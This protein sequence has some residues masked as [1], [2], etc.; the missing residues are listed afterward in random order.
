[1]IRWHR[2]GAMLAAA[3]LCAASAAAGDQ[4][5]DGRSERWRMPRDV[6]MLTSRPD[7]Y[8]WRLFVAL[9]WPVDLST[10]EPDHHA[11]LGADRPVV[12]ES[13]PSARELLKPDGSDPGRWRA[14][15]A[16]ATP[17]QR[18]ETMSLKELPNLRHIVGGVMVPVEDPIASARRLTDI[19]FNRT[20]FEFIRARQLFNVNGQV[21]AYESGGSI[22]LPYGAV[23]VKAKWRQ[24]EERERTR[25]HTLEVTMADGTRRLYG[26]TALHIAS[27][28]RPDWFW[29]TF[30]H[31]DNPTLPDSEG[32]L[33]PSRDRFACRG[34]QA[35]CNR[36]P[37]GLGLEGTV[38]SNYRLR[39]TMT[40]YV[41]AQGEPERLANSELETDMQRTASCVTCH[42]RAS[43]GVREH[44][45]VHRSILD[46]AVGP[47]A[48]ATQRRGFVGEPLWL[49]SPVPDNDVRMEPVDFVW[50]LA[51]VRVTAP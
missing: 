24:I 33:L 36:A 9:N 14:S 20:S 44:Q 25:Y 43:I 47:D 21:R 16:P 35:D 48:D 39:G 50:S 10:R 51:G 23:N 2:A 38:W 7:E 4:G 11:R 15:R 22:R 12:W 28:D 8:A 32:W 37:S 30:E 46:V 19:H 45:L 41:N 13:W 29:S 31:V 18:F 26:L 49:K 34:E 3:L 42:S 27:K 1:M 40:D 17:Q 6:S 5:A